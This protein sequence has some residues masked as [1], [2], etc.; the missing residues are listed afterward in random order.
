MNNQLMSKKSLYKQNIIACVWDFDK[1]LIP[2]YMQTPLFDAFGIDEKLFWKEVNALP[3][4]YQKKGTRVSSDTIYLN[5]LISYVKNGILEGLTNA[6]LRELGKAL[7]FCP[8]LPELFPFWDGFQ[9]FPKFRS[10][11][12]S[13]WN[14]LW[15]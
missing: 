9:D 2:G 13:F 12:K 1:T 6:K 5:H 8:G 10:N 14:S 3:E 4:I 15:R 7:K 11:I